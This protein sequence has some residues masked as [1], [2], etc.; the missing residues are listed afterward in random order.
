MS[1]ETE[2]RSLLEPAAARALSRT[3]GAVRVS[4]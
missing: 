2:I 4:R 1:A 3:E